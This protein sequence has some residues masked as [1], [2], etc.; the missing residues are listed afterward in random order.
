M[1]KALEIRAQ[2]QLK[3]PRLFI[4]WSSRDSLIKKFSKRLLHN[5]LP[6]SDLYDKGKCLKSE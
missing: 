2:K 5:G 3:G 6:L 4:L 1:V